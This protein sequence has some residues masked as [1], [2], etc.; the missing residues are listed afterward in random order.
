MRL[1]T[2]CIFVN[3]QDFQ[4]TTKIRF[5][6][7]F[8]GRIFFWKILSVVLIFTANF[9]FQKKNSTNLV[10]PFGDFGG[11]PDFSDC[12][13]KVGYLTMLELIFGTRN[14]QFRWILNRFWWNR[15]QPSSEM[16]KKV[17]RTSENRYRCTIWRENLEV[18]DI[19]SKK[20]W[21]LMILKSFLGSFPMKTS[22]SK[23]C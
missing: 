21:F 20:W 13:L 22:L 16:P 6:N 18:H 2:G 9:F 15:P 14:I 12:W 1:A 8:G 10:F 23:G 7:I 5:G 3:Y 17:S 4:A 19:F 11:N